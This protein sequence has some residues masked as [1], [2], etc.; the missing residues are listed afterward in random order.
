MNPISEWNDKLI[1]EMFFSSIRYFRK[2]KKKRWF[3]IWR[4]AM[5]IIAV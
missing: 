4:N 5:I 3:I 2:N 1:F